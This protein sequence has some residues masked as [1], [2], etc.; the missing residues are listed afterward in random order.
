MK[1]KWRLLGAAFPACEPLASIV[2][3]AAGAELPEFYRSLLVHTD[4]MTR[5][6]ERF[7]KCPVA[8]RVLA[9]RADGPIYSRKI[10]LL[11]HGTG[12]QDA[13]NTRAAVQF[14]FAQVDLEA[15]SGAVRSDILA[16]R[17][18]LGRI[19]IDNRV[20]CRI[21]PQAFLKVTTDRGLSDLF[22]TQ[23]GQVT[24]GRIARI[25]CDGKPAIEVIEVPAPA[26]ANALPSP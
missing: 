24:Y 5:V 2:E 3:P 1:V 20:D 6:M 13:E 4:H 15:V 17:V 12:T 9:R 21:E 10:V 18:P 16:E 19:L 26:N 11:K 25:L 23:A 8:V 22:G 14:A 7:H